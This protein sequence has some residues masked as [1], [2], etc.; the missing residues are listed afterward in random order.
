LTALR[1]LAA[2]GYNEPVQP[3]QNS[4]LRSQA[5]PE[6]AGL[7]LDELC[8]RIIRRELVGHPDPNRMENEDPVP[9][10][11]GQRL[12]DIERAHIERVYRQMGGNISRAA[13][14]LGI[15]RSTLYSKLK[16]YASNQPKS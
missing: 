6:E 8:C 7:P 4:F 12:R 2:L 13:K 11:P 10:D 3:D 5:R 15:D 16:S 1:T 14:V 9:T